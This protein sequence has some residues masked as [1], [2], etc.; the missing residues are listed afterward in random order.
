LEKLVDAKQSKKL[1][2]SP[3]LVP[4]LSIVV[5]L[6]FGGVLIFIQGIDPLLAYRVLFTLLLDPLMESQLL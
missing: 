6:A 1:D 2:F 5:A 4:L 3:I